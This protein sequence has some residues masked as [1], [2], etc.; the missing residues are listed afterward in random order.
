MITQTILN[1]LQFSRLICVEVS[2]ITLIINY[3]A[4][5]SFIRLHPMAT[6]NSFGKIIVDKVFPCDFSS[7]IPE[8][9]VIDYQRPEKRS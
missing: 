3:T 1:V 4:M 6:Y 7:R 9:N 5:L 8:H 2:L